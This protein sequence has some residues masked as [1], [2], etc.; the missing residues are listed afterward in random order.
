MDPHEIARPDWPRVLEQFS[1]EHR[2]WL[3]SVADTV[4]APLRSVAMDGDAIVVRLGG[5][6]ELRIEAPSALRIEELGLDI[7][8]AAGVTR[9]RFRAAAPADALDGLAPA[10][11]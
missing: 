6:P 10:E 7:Q 5:V 2:G 4:Q 9:V 3:A 1:R 8:A 11:R